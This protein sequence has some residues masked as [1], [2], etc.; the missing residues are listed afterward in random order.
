MY[1][2]RRTTVYLPDDLKAAVERLAARDGRSEA[3]VIRAALVVATT[4][5]GAPRPRVPL[6][7]SGDPAL[8]ER[9]DEVLA[10]GFGE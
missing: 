8:A 10:E 9:V 7:D 2:M 4:E 3:E 6:F 1:G 5:T